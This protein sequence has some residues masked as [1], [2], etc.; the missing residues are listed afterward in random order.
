MAPAPPV[1]LQRDPVMEKQAAALI[2]RLGYNGSC[3]LDFIRRPD[4]SLVFL[5]FNARPT[6]PPVPMKPAPLS[7]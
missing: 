5:E 6:P 7:P 3:G 2:A 4:N 1:R